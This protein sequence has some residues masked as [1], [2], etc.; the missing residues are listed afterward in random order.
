VPNNVGRPA[1]KKTRVQIEASRELWSKSRSIILQT[2]VIV[3]ASFATVVHSKLVLASLPTDLTTK[4][5]AVDGPVKEREI[6]IALQPSIK[7][8]EAKPSL[9]WLVLSDQRG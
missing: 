6:S 7:A 1:L 5:A 9:R 3:S 2:R 4:A 8:E